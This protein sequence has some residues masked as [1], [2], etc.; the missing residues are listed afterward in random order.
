[1]ATIDESGLTIKT[2]QQYLIEIKNKLLAIDSGWDVLPASP[3][4]MKAQ[5]DAEALAKLEEDFAAIYASIDPLTAIGKQLDRIGLI[6]NTPRKGATYSTNT[7]TFYGNDGAIIP[8]G[9]TVRH[10]TSGTTWATNSDAKINKDSVEVPVTCTTAGAVSANIDTL[11]DIQGGFPAGVS[12]C[13]NKSAASM[14]QNAEDDDSY[15][16]RREKSVATCSTNAVDSIFAKISPLAGVKNIKVMQNKSQIA[17]SVGLEPRSILVIVD[18]GKDEEIARG[19]AAVKVPG[20]PDNENTNISSAKVV[21]DTTTPRGNPC[22]IA[23][24]RPKYVSIFVKIELTSGAF[25]DKDRENLKQYIVDYSLTGYQKGSGFEKKGFGIGDEVGLGR[26]YTP[27]N[28]YVGDAGVV[29]SL[30]IGTTAA[31]VGLL[32]I[33]VAFNEL[34]VFDKDNIDIEVKAP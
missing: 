20:V 23:F 8:K 18:G 25:S 3:D 14:G 2:M 19:L 17:D 30:K 27:V 34:P 32:P 9:T 15:R 24:F 22:R 11:T 7:V 6:T 31:N 12:S 16:Q 13:T 1:M 10:K 33:V 29:N 5:S 28:Y 26:I 21:L 4:G